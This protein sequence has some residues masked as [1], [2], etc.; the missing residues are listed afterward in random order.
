MSKLIPIA[1][2]GVLALSAGSVVLAQSVPRS[3]HDAAH[4]AKATD[5]AATKDFKAAHEKMSKAMAISY[6]NNTDLDFVRGMIPHHK[7]AIDMAKVQ[8]AHGKD[9]ALRAMAE[10]VIADQ[11]K[12]IAEMQDWLK[13]N[14]K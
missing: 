14:S 1:I 12:E 13:K 11:Q 4:T 8:L 6:T 5:P 3:S 7:G 2:A 10:K 9:P